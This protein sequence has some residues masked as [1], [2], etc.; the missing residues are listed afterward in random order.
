VPE[1]V[2]DEEEP[3]PRAPDDDPEDPPVELSRDEDVLPEEDTP[4]AFAV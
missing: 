2:P 3:E 4:S 1:L